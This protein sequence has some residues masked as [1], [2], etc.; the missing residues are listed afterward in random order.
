MRLDFTAEELDRFRDDG[1]I[2]AI[3]APDPRRRAQPGELALGELAGRKYPGIAKLVAIDFPLENLP[4]LPIAD[5]AHRR[6]ARPQ[7][8]AFAQRTQLFD[9]PH[10]QH[11]IEAFLD[12]PMQ[13]AAIGRNERELDEAEGED[14]GLSS[15]EQLRHRHT[16][17]PKDLE[18]RLD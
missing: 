18:R 9:E 17:H 4:R 1:G 15:L 7:R 16:A 10:F 2:E 6:Q 12:A 11:R 5:A 8:V 13:R 14:C 3:K